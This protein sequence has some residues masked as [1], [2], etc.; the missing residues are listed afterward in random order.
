MP[1]TM[2]RGASGRQRPAGQHPCRP[3]MSVSM[4]S[5]AAAWVVAGPPGAGKSTVAA[6]CWPAAPG[7]RAAGQG[8]DVRA[9]RGRDAGRGRAPAGRA[10]GPVVRRARQG[11][12]VRRDDGH[13]AGDPRRTAARCCCPGRSPGR[14]TMPAAGG[15]GSPTWAAAR[16]AWS[17]SART[18]PRC[19]AGWPPAARAGT[20]PSWPTSRRSPPACGSAPSPR[21]RTPRSTTAVDRARAA[22]RPGHRAVAGPTNTWQS[23]CTAARPRRP[24]PSAPSAITEAPAPSWLRDQLW[25][26]Q[27]TAAT[28]VAGEHRRTRVTPGSRPGGL[29]SPAGPRSGVSGLAPGGARHHPGRSPG[30]C[31]SIGPVTGRAAGGRLRRGDARAPSRTRPATVPAAAAGW[32]RRS[33]KPRAHVRDH[34]N[35]SALCAT[36]SVITKRS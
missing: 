32:A 25:M 23:G 11:A 7:P 34:G 10:R 27:A 13:R 21:R 29:R 4:A 2:P 26:S 31:R 17:G 12:R 28:G 24:P 5:R 20:R 35:P 30:R 3:V 33:F 19:T 18:R 22:G 14:S 16:C 8:H 15:P 6:C 9:V 36:R 1:V